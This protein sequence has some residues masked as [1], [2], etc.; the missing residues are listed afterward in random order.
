[1]YCQFKKVQNPI[2]HTLANKALKEEIPHTLPSLLKTQGGVREGCREAIRE[3]S[4]PTQPK[5]QGA[6]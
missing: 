3:K 5:G 6:A 2:S 4:Q 1:M